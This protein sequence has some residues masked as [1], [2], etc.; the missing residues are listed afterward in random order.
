MKVYQKKTKGITLIEAIIS[1][2]LFI[3]ALVGGY[4]FF[5]K[6]MEKENLNLL[7]LDTA[8]RLNTLMTA[9]EEYVK[10]K[11]FITDT[12][13]TCQ[14]L[15]NENF[16]TNE[17]LCIDKIGNT[18]SGIVTIDPSTQQIKNLSIRGIVSSNFASDMEKVGFFRLVNDKLIQLSE[19]K[20]RLFYLSKGKIF[21]GSAPYGNLIS[22]NSNETVQ[23]YLNSGQYSSTTTVVSDVY[24]ARNL[25]K[26]LGYWLWQVEVNFDLSQNIFSINF[27]NLGYSK[28]CIGGKLPLN[29]NPNGTV[30][31]TY[32]ASQDINPWNTYVYLT[33]LCIPIHKSYV[34][35]A[36]TLPSKNS[37]VSITEIFS[38]MND[39]PCIRH[40]N[41]NFCCSL[42][43]QQSNVCKEVYWPLYDS[44]GQIR[45]NYELIGFLKNN[46][47][48]QSQYSLGTTKINYVHYHVK[49]LN[50]YYQIFILQ[51][52]PIKL[53]TTVR[54]RV[55]VSLIKSQQNPINF[56]LE[57]SNWQT[58][59]VLPSIL[60]YFNVQQT[61]FL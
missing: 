22:G 36:K 15:K 59:T 5:Y 39:T 17:Q 43:N 13:I 6:Q 23:N 18:F 27:N 45:S 4:K 40:L 10:T 21:D 14:D 31:F 41:R 42:N 47:W 49:V 29:I 35:L 55:Y 19:G 12:T 48:F 7:A 9:L 1:L 20:Y 57:I 30:P 60:N 58:S 44:Q 53:N 56:N 2:V 34:D 11:T 50:T 25:E 51:A 28:V 54:Q 32:A 24:I 33:T 61:I 52:H 37:A 46:P 3:I 26:S 38:N 16:I 8:Q